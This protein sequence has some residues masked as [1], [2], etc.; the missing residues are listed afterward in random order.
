MSF[1][2]NLKKCIGLEICIWCR[3]GGKYPTRGKLISVDEDF[4]FA[5]IKFVDEDFHTESFV[6]VKDIT[7]FATVLSLKDKDKNNII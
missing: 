1:G 4:D 6:R 7:R 2:N 5:Y 3:D